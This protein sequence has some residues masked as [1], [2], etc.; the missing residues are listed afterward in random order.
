MNIIPI[1]FD[2]LHIFDKYPEKNMDRKESKYTL[3]SSS[4]G[5]PKVYLGA[6]VVKL[7]YGNDYYDWT[8]ISDLYVQAAIKNMKKISQEI[9]YGI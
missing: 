7:L 4:I 2:N 9:W 1:F 3:K 8:M 5:D 6:N